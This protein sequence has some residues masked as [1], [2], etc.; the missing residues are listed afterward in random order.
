[1]IH[2]LVLAVHL[3]STIAKLVRPGGV[4]AVVAE[5][6]LLKQQLLISSRARCRA[7]N[8]NSFDRFFLGLGSLFV[9]AS[10]I[11]KLAVILKP[12][13]L[14]R[15]H[16]A[17]KKC[18][19]RWLFSSGG[20]RRPGPKGPSKELID[21]IV[22]FK[23]RNPRVGCPRIAQQLAH[24]FGIDINK[25]IVRRVLAKH[26]RPEAGTDGPSWLS[27]IGHVKD[28]LWRVDL[29]DVQPDHRRKAASSA[30]EFRPRPAISFPSLARQLA[31]TRGRKRSSRS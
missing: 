6:L 26:Y 3:L 10:R 30:P 18:K 28:S 16:A 21:A 15:F 31:H 8:L 1:M 24:A 29:S 9:P 11:P 20:H 2:L 12:R 23:R 19:Y 27:F 4:R 7:P 17:L 14:L 13:T 25:D 5:S 22:E